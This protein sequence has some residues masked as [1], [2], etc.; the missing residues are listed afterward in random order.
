MNA[1]TLLAATGGN[2]AL[3]R[4]LAR[5]CLHKD[6]PR[7]RARL[8][9]AARDRD[10]EALG[11]AAHALK[12]LVAEFRA[13][14]ARDAAA[15]VEAAAREKQWAHVPIHLASFDDEYE[16]LARLLRAILAETA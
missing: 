15:Q 2:R 3:L 6:A 5:L 9:Q 7:L 13:S 16:K 1:D 12:G 8:R 11:F 14:A 4:E 10:S